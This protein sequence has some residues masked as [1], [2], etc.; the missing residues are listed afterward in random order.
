MVVQSFAVC[1]FEFM[2]LQSLLTSQSVSHASEFI[3]VPWKGISQ[4]PAV[5]SN[6][7]RCR[8]TDAESNFFLSFLFMMNRAE[9]E[10]GD[11]LSGLSLSA[12]IYSL[13]K[14]EDTPLHTKNWRYC[15]RNEKLL[16]K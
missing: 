11:G 9:K 3:R 7:L 4:T 12:A 15:V 5:R 8:K 10:W 16:L 6:K 13:L 2:I 1:E 14:I